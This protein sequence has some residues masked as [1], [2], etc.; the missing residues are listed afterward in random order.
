[1]PLKTTKFK[2]FGQFNRAVMTDAK[3]LG[4][5]ADAGHDAQDGPNHQQGLVLLRCQSFPSRRRFAEFQ[6]AAK[7]KAEISN[8]GKI[9]IGKLF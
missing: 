2:P 8:S 5:T 9:R 3:S 6:E 7:G 1:M 4:E